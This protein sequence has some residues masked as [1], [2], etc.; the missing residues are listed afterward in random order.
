[1]CILNEDE[2]ISQLSLETRKRQI[3]IAGSPRWMQ[4]W[5]VRGEKSATNFTHDKFHARAYTT[6]SVYNN[7]ERDIAAHDERKFRRWCSPLILSPSLLLTSWTRPASLIIA[8]FCHGFFVARNANTWEV[9][10]TTK[11]MSSRLALPVSGPARHK[12]RARDTYTVA[13]AAT[14]S[15]ARMCTSTL[16]WAKWGKEESTEGEHTEP[17]PCKRVQVN[18]RIIS[19][20]FI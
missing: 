18:A 10:K 13:A 4:M 16:T 1:M 15:C 2:L 6:S 14:F 11:I 19:T 7:G 17:K 3:R 5:R 8:T 12:D 9:R 20:A